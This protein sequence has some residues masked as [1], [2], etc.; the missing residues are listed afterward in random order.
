MKISYKILS[1]ICITLL[2]NACSRKQLDEETPSILTAD[3][4]FKTKDG[5]EYALNGLFDEV[6]R[7]RAGEPAGTSSTSVN[8]IMNIQA[9]IGVDNAYGNYRDPL[10]DVYNYYG[11]YNSASQSH[12]SIV[13]AWLYETINAVNTIVNRSTN[14]AINWSDADKNRIL[15]EARLIRA[16]C[17]RHLTNLW[18][19]VPLTLTESSG[20]NIRTDWE[21]TCC[22][23]KKSHGR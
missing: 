22:P 19:D 9:V 7:Y 13:F 23:G 15:A 18:G 2:L 17:Y 4:L 5:F 16:W 1:V 21:R 14:P 10:L 20:T 6:R 3:L 12:G 8:N 11:T